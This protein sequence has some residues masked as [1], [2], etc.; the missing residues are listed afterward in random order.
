MSSAFE[1]TY[2]QW[3]RGLD[4]ADG[5]RKVFVV[6]CPK[7]GTTWL[8]NLL[9]AHER[10]VIRGE[11]AFTWQ[12]VPILAQAFQV[13]NEHQKHMDPV[14]QLRDLDLLL[15]ARAM[16]DGQFH[17][18]L[19]ESG[20]DLSRV[21][22]VGDK[23]PQHT[24]S[25]PLLNRLYPGARFIHI[26]RDPRDTAVSAWF[27]FGKSDGRPF[28][29]YIEYYLTRVWPLNVG[30]ARQA[31]P[32]LGGAYT[33]VRYEDLVRDPSPQV[34]R[35]LAH[36]GVENGPAAIEGCIAAARFEKKSG[37]RAPGQTDNA[38][39][40]RT[41]TSGDWRNHIPA[42]LADRC[43][44]SIAPLMRACGYEPTAG[45]KAEAAPAGGC[46]AR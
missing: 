5:F 8:A 34:K 11:G 16:I 1:T 40:Y 20:R 28:E 32:A 14:A 37:G 13:F 7:S 10:I 46:G 27:H 29:T 4:H 9:D 24:L 3:R 31:A 18:Y 36:V 6:G 23:T 41:G 22:V 39:F 19:I 25:M 45:E 30:T 35:L 43:C 26:L 42:D 38:S 15:V 17:R 33:E 21:R 44:A 12:L 2:Q